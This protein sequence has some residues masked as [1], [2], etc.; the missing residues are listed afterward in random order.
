[1]ASAACSGPPCSTDRDV[2]LPARL[3]GPG[4][5]SARFVHCSTTFCAGHRGSAH[6]L[7]PAPFFCKAHVPEACSRKMREEPCGLRLFCSP[8]TAGKKTCRRGVCQK[9]AR[10]LS[11]APEAKRLGPDRLLLEKG[12]CVARADETVG[13]WGAKKSEPLL[14]G[15]YRKFLTCFETNLTTN[16]ISH[17]NHVRQNRQGP[18]FL[19]LPDSL[20]PGGSARNSV[21]RS[22][23]KVFLKGLSGSQEERTPVCHDSEYH[24]CRH[25]RSGSALSHQQLPQED[26]EQDLLLLRRWFKLLLFDKSCRRREDPGL[27]LQR[28]EAGWPLC[29]ILPP[30][31]KSFLAT[32]FSSSSVRDGRPPEIFQGPASVR[33][34]WGNSLEGLAALPHMVAHGT[35]E[36]ETSG[37]MDAL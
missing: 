21:Q 8:C 6:S 30:P 1:M 15:K 25:H 17:I 34:M 20:F 27:P 28:E 4:R 31:E 5:G 9:P 13:G 22:F 11:D 26:Q 33:E 3:P 14:A 37:H 36:R 24:C 23:S 12:Q 29:V 7:T 19:P 32:L 18:F 2:A 16:S 35:G 10:S